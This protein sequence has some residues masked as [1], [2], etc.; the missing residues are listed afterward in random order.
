MGKNER[1]CEIR[2]SNN[3]HASG[4]DHEKVATT[5]EQRIRA[6]PTQQGRFIFRLSTAL[7]PALFDVP[8]V[9]E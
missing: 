3:L 7:F 1:N 6:A 5:K 9:A 2:L 4:H 8:N